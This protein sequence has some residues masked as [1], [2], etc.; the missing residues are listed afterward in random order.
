V[1]RKKNA[2]VDDDGLATETVGHDD[3]TVFD[4][5]V[6]AGDSVD[7]AAWL[8]DEADDLP[9]LFEG[10]DA[11]PADEEAELDLETH[12][13]AETDSDPDQEH[14]VLARGDIYATQ[15]DPV[16][17]YLQE[18]GAVPLL[19]PEAETKIAI[20]I[21][22]GEKR[23]QNAL[24]ISPPAIEYLKEMAD[25]VREGKRAVTDLLRG[26]D[27]ADNAAVSTAAK[28]FLWQVAEADR[29]GQEITALRL[30]L[31]KAKGNKTNA[32]KIKTRIARNTK[33]MAAVF[34]EDRISAKHLNTIIKRLRK[35][36]KKLRPEPALA[37]AG[38]EKCCT[39]RCGCL[40]AHQID[41]EALA[42]ILTEVTA[43]EA[44]SR[45][46]KNLLVQANL[47]LVVSVAKKYANR[48]LQLLDLIQEGNIGL[49]KAVE[50][51]E[52]RRGYKFSTYAT[53][54]IR[55]AITRAIAD[56]GRT[57]RIPV[58]MIDTINRLLKGAKDFLRETGRE[59][60]PEEMA[61]RLEVDLSKVKNILKIAKEPLSLD[62]PIGS[63]EDSYL[64]DFIEDS[65]TMAPDEA[66][67]LDNLRM[68]LRRVLKTLTPREE[69]VLRMRFGIDTAVDLTLEEVGE[70]FS[71]TRERIRQIEAKALKKLKHPSRRNLLHSFYND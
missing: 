46:S 1:T 35:L 70:S 58:H 24:L 5:G 37:K 27:E 62:T 48:G 4:E 45:E 43:G 29:L 10:H 9:P 17:V 18:M 14:P 6:I 3:E 51:F 52:Y 55:Q 64:A 30:D 13:K 16:K 59:P 68:S 66:T 22:E 69:M 34:A 71:V 8:M 31:L 50:K 15:L 7:E 47:R 32:Q 21:E 42:E 28:H 40:K 56:Q 38:A 67:M 53:W 49:M 12:P 44:V 2:A 65:S 54:W 57:I 11:E 25:K 60:T 61:E 20:R 33:T 36:E 39:Y 23:I 63:G 41:H 19:S 26:L